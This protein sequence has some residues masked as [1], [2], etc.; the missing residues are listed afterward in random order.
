ML[1]KIKDFIVKHKNIIAIIAVFTLLCV[2]IFPPVFVKTGARTATYSHRIEVDTDALQYRGYIVKDD[3]YISNTNDSQI[4]IPLTNDTINDVLIE[5]HSLIKNHENAQLY[6]SIDNDLREKDSISKSAYYQ[7]QLYFTIPD[8]VYKILRLDLEGQ[9][10]ID[11]VYLSYATEVHEYTSYQ[12]KVGNLILLLSFLAIGITAIILLKKQIKSSALFIKNRYFSAE[13]IKIAKAKKMANLFFTLAM[14]FGMLFIY[15]NPPFVCPDETAHFINVC[16]ISHGEWFPVVENNEIGCHLTR[17]EID[18]TTT[19]S[20]LFNGFNGP[21]FEYL[22]I[23]NFTQA[24]NDTTLSFFPTE[25]ATI[26]PTSYILSGLAVSIARLMVSNIHPYSILLLAKMV[27]LLFFSL[28]TRFAIITTPIMKNTM[29]VLALMPMTLY[30]CSSVSYDAITIPACFLLF[31]YGAKILLSAE[32]YV[33]TVPDIIGI[34][35][36]FALICGS[37]IAYAPIIFIFLTIAIKKFGSIKK[38]LICIGIIGAI[39]VLFYIIPSVVNNAISANVNFAYADEIA[40]QREYYYS[41]IWKTPII[42]NDTIEYFSEYW[43]V[44]FVGILGAL[45]TYFPTSLTLIFLAFS[46]LIAITD[47]CMIKKIKISTR[48]TSF[49][50]VALITS[51]SIITMYIEWN[52]RVIEDPTGTIAYGMQGRYFIPIALLALLPF[53]NTLLSKFKY[54]K[55]L[56]A[57]E[58]N[59]IKIMSIG[60]LVLTSALLLTRYW[61]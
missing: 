51:V 38:Y 8:G 37:K 10:K 42:I 3:V 47:L 13:E 39:G 29:F 61:I 41:N 40:Q 25:Y 36:S 20:G 43:I 52:P 22:T 46:T 2:I 14:I 24:Q 45:D 35:L 31:A 60:Y 1:I 5:F 11:A 4:W 16:R 56:L 54:S 23:Y 17:S 55:N 59:A 32:D 57:I 50:I 48:L 7:D 9:F 26:N 27:N 34:C 12:V 44:S 15:L 33:I 30:Q 53:S 49:A 28:V 21:K 6:Y 58:E 19:F 18:F